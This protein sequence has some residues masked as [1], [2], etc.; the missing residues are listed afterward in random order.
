VV[1]TLKGRILILILATLL[2]GVGIIIFLIKDSITENVTESVNESNATLNYAIQANIDNYLKEKSK[3]LLTLN[4]SEEVKNLDYEA[5][6]KLFFAA[7]E[8]DESFTNVYFCN[9]AGK[10]DV[11]VP[12]GDVGED[13]DGRTRQWYQLAE[14]SGQVSYSDV[15]IDAVTGDP[16]IAISYPVKDSEGVFRGV[17]A[18]DV[19]LSAL[20][21]LVNTQKIGDTGFVYITDNNGKVIT[22]PNQE[23]VTQS[24]DLSSNDYV[25]KALAGENGFYNHGEQLIYY[26]QIPS[27]GWGLFIEQTTSEA[28]AVQHSIIK[29][30]TVIASIMFIIVL[31]VSLLAVNKL[32]AILNSLSAGVKRYAEGDFTTKITVNYDTELGE[33]GHNI[34]SMGE[35]LRGLISDIGTTSQSLASHSQQLAAANEEVSASIQEVANTTNEMSASAGN[36]YSVAVKSVTEAN[37]TKVTAQQ[38]AKTVASLIRQNSEIN[39]FSA[40]IVSSMNELTNLSSEIG[41]ITSVISGIAEQTNLLALNAAIEA[42]RAGEHGRGFA[43]VADEVRKLAEQS[44]KSTSEITQIIGK[45]Q[46]SITQISE[47]LYATDAMRSKSAE[48]AEDANN[49]LVNIQQAVQHTIEVVEGMATGIKQTNEGMEHVAGSNE[50]VSSAIQQMNGS[51]QE[52]AELANK[53]NYAVEKFKI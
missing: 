28:Y 16:V 44:S 4:A 49:A 12:H 14:S 40:E 35:K 47:L 7:I 5:M 45:V 42:A 17:L 6:D 36:D 26:S 34:N 41:N 25:K 39:E 48:L 11:L 46:G 38:G 9:T 22:H 52:L 33:L 19:S 13:F 20:T 23:L 21:E 24:K 51:A 37:E 10:L 27:T 18:A 43:V 29:R 53:L 31:A 15:Y 8:G 1:K 3:L 32:T 50:Q 30:I 2:V